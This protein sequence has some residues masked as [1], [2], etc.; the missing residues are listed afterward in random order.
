MTKCAAL[1]RSNPALNGLPR[2]GRIAWEL[3]SLISSRERAP[4]ADMM[5]MMRKRERRESKINMV[6]VGQRLKAAKL[7]RHAKEAKIDSETL[8]EPER[9]RRP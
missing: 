9:R 6:V 4:T 2:V 5:L 7:H 1:C 8:L 3:K